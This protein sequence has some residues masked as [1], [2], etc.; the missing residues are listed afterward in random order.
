MK[1]KQRHSLLGKVMQLPLL[2]VIGLAACGGSSSPNTGHQYKIGIALIAS[3]DVLQ[4]NIDTF[5]KGLASRGLVDGT[6]LTYIEKNA[7]GDLSTVSLI[8]QQMV[9]QKPDLIYV[10]GTPLVV[11]FHQQTK[12]IPV[13]FGVMTDPVGQGVV[14][15]AQA[16]GGNFTGTSDFL[17]AST[18]FDLIQ[19]VL[20]QAKKIGI[21][22]NPSEQNTAGQIKLLQAEADKRALQLVSAPTAS[23]NDILPAV[24]SLKGR[25][26][27][28]IVTQDATLN[29][30]IPT[31]SKVALDNRI[32]LFGTGGADGASQGILVAYGVDYGGVG[33]IA[34]KEAVDI[35]THGANPATIPVYYANQQSGLII[36]VNVGTAKTLGITLPDA[37]L[38]QAQSVGG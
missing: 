21:L 23:T 1:L 24:Q 28:A 11:A 34:A 6:N 10:V 37:L 15:S 19:Q 12:T 33:D 9:Q 22:G 4:A 17:P 2:L 26:D 7:Q 38:K 30:A 13:L 5:K 3:V 31:V 18:T 35:L 29:S 8:A 32:P 16:P 20:P 14:A 27:A 36:K 25:V